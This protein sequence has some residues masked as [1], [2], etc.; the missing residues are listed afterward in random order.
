MSITKPI[1]IQAL[2]GLRR[3]EGLFRIFIF[4]LVTVMF[5]IGFSIFFS[6]TKTKI[7]VDTKK[8]TV[9][10]NPNINREILKDA[11]TRTLY[12]DQEL[13]S[14]PIYDRLVSEKSGSKLVIAGTEAQEAKEATGQAIVVPASTTVISTESA[15]VKLPS[16]TVTATASSTASS[17]ATSTASPS[18]TR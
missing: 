12:T 4:S 3:R 2:E 7:S 13:Q 5:W 16:E 17:S 18:A 14:F 8:Y 6:Q 9:P 11:A 15:K 10:L 1:Y